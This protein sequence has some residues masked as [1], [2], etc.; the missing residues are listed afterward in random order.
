MISPQS[1][2]QVGQKG[3][4]GLT[5]CISCY[6]IHISVTSVVLIFYKST[7]TQTIL[8]SYQGESSALNVFS[9]SEGRNHQNS[10]IYLQ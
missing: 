7:N 6:L 2:G 4:P 3:E 8:L 5:V 10:E 1:Q 9:F